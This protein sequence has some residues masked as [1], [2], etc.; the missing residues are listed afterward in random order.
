MP[1]LLDTNVISELRKAPKCDVKLLK[2]AQSTASQQHYLSILTLGEIRKGIEMLRLHSPQQCEAFER[3]LR[4]LQEEYHANL[5]PVSA[6]VIDR[7]G[8]LMATRTFPV[9]DGLLAATALTFDL[10]L[11]TRNVDDFAG[12]G[13]GLVNPF[14]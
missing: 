12:S 13:V 11:A 3:W 4:Q 7:W 8:R 10:T 5:L 1:Y 9:I 6:S 2:W 14:A